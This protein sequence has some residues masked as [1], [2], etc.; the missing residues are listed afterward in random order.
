[1]LKNAFSV[2]NVLKGLRWVST[3]HDTL[4]KQT[5]LSRPN[6]AALCEAV[7]LV[8]ASDSPDRG[9]NMISERVTHSD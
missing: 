7:Y 2:V 8:A 4:R 3:S 9:V 5:G 1:M 6:D